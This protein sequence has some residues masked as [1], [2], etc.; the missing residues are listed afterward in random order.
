MA[1]ARSKIALIMIPLGKKIA[2]RA[3]AISIPD[4]TKAPLLGVALDVG[5][6]RGS[7]NQDQKHLVHQE[8]IMQAWA[9]HSLEFRPTN[10]RTINGVN[11]ES[12]KG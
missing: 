8:A 12:S 2:I 7:G 9:K 1:T 11:R 10:H 5:S 3:I 4:L 6:G